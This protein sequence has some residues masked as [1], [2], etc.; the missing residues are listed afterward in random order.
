MR[1]EEQ[2]IGMSTLPDFGYQEDN[3]LLS[4]SSESEDK[5]QLLSRLVIGKED[6]FGWLMNFIKMKQYEKN[7]YKYSAI[8][9]FAKKARAMK[10]NQ[11]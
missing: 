1:I 9:E 2:I 7:I 10:K 8:A 11:L 4:K 6:K 3:Y 5:W